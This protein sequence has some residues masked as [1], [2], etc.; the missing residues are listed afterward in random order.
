MP[1][2]FHATAPL[3]KPLLQASLRAALAVVRGWGERDSISII[4]IM[5]TG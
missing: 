1:E 3:K 4:N 5:Y 2:I